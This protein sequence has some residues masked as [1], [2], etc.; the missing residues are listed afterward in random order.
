[1]SPFLS[2]P[3]QIPAFSGVVGFAETLKLVVAGFAAVLL[4]ISLTGYR[5]TKSKRLLLV[6]GAFTVVLARVLIVEN[7][8]LLFPFLSLDVVDL[9]RSTMDLAMLLLF[10]LAV[11]KS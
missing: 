4:F 6:S 9:V 2:I 3:L 8:T 10:F 5:R 11:V 7:S 1:M